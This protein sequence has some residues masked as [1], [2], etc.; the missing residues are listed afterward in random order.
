M[1]PTKTPNDGDRMEEK[2]CETRTYRVQKGPECYYI[3]AGQH[4]TWRQVRTR[5]AGGTN[6]HQEQGYR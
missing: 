6:K 2:S 1:A 3:V 4:D 5:L